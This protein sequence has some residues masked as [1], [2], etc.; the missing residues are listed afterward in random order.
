[1]RVRIHCHADSAVTQ[2]FLDHLGMDTHTEQES[3]RAMP[4]I[5]EPHRRKASFLEEVLKHDMKLTLI[6]K[7]TIPIAEHQIILLPHPAVSLLQHHTVNNL[8]AI[9]GQIILTNRSLER[10]REGQ[11]SQSTLL[12]FHRLLEPPIGE[13]AANSDEN[14]CRF[15]LEIR[16]LALIDK[17]WV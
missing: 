14:I 12:S 3:S 5:M 6:E 8:L 7:C 1:M 4:Q 16:T 2:N 11:R 15:Y 9:L 13:S 10:V 17:I